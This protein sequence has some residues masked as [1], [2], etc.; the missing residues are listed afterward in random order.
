MKRNHIQ[1]IGAKSKW[2]DASAD[3]KDLVRL[4]KKNPKVYSNPNMPLAALLNGCQKVPWIVEQNPVLGLLALE[5]PQQ[6]ESLMT[7]LAAGWTE[8][9]LG[10]LSKSNKAL[11]AADCAEHVLPTFEKQN[12]SPAPRQAIQAVRDFFQGK[13]SINAVVLASSTAQSAAQSELDVNF[14]A[15]H[16]GLAAGFAA[17]A[18]ITEHAAKEAANEAVESVTYLSKRMQERQWQANRVRYYYKLEH[19]EYEL[20]EKI[21]AKSP[22]FKDPALDVEK[23]ERLLKRGDAR[24]LSNPNAPISLLLKYAQSHPVEVE[25]NPVLGMLGLEDPAT[26]EELVKRINQG[27]RSAGLE[28]LTVHNKARYVADCIEYAV[29]SITE[30]ALV[31]LAHQ[32]ITFLRSWASQ[33]A[34]PDQ[35]AWPSGYKD[36]QAHIR[37]A[38]QHYHDPKIFSK[39]KVRDIYFLASLA[40]SVADWFSPILATVHLL[41]FETRDEGLRARSEASLAEAAAQA[42]FVRKYYYK[43]FPIPP[44]EIK[45]PIKKKKPSGSVG[46]MAPFGLSIQ[47]EN[48]NPMQLSAFEILSPT[49]I[50]PF[51]SLWEMYLLEDGKLAIRSNDAPVTKKISPVS[52]ELYLYEEAFARLEP[53]ANVPLP[54]EELM[55]FFADCLDWLIK[56]EESSELRGVITYAAKALRGVNKYSIAKSMEAAV[57]AGEE[58]ERWKWANK[59]D[60][61]TQR[62]AALVDILHWAE[63]GAS[64]DDCSVIQKLAWSNA[65]D[66]ASLLGTDRM[67][68]VLEA[69][70]AFAG[71]LEQRLLSLQGGV[72][73]GRGK[74]SSFP[75]LQKFLAL[76]QEKQN[77]IRDNNDAWLPSDMKGKRVYVHLNLGHKWDTRGLG[78]WSVKYGPSKK[79]VGHVFGLRLRNVS[80]EVAPAGNM[81]AVIARDKVVHAFVVGDL[82]EASLTPGWS[83][84]TEGYIPLRYSPDRSEDLFFM[85]SN[86]GKDWNVPVSGAEEVLAIG[87][88]GRPIEP[89]PRRG[90]KFTFPWRPLLARG[91][92][93]M[94]SDAIAEGLEARQESFLRSHQGWEEFRARKDEI[95]LLDKGIEPSTIPATLQKGRKA[96]WARYSRLGEAAIGRK[97]RYLQLPSS[98]S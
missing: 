18:V 41:V 81:Q 26:V 61:D 39:S 88:V 93:D 19:P 52:R 29:P 40:N 42:S 12:H 48:P 70:K 97:R 60:N 67:T 87:G 59:R 35:D 38:Q 73:A 28:K 8:A 94:T 62:I 20:P 55:K 47:S 17:V 58:I 82:V 22:Q 76:S 98:R 80:F 54:R 2:N 77:E 57:A 23:I 86:N 63:T 79:L 16:A 49:Y 56:D 4:A 33:D 3:P 37:A 68:P 78:T 64:L 91:V 85:R 31:S 9:G 25:N 72:V 53:R 44:A 13:G 27:W 95:D 96:R 90:W 32:V 71:L 24:A 10:K 15:Y 50:E 30:Q 1:H 6:L 36:L 14:S 75:T 74:S 84:S 83:P 92:Q 7:C 69:Y 34:W 21:G 43:Q 51:R 65:D 66:L 11:Y 89:P 46:A 45:R 5:D